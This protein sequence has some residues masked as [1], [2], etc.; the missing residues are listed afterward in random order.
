MLNINWIGIKT[1]SYKEIARFIS[2]Y[3]Q[4]IIAP[5]I[6][7]LIFIAIF[8]FSLNEHVKIIENI[9]FIK[10]IGS[11]LIMMTI[12]QN[13]YA[14]TS[15]ILT[16]SKISGFISDYIMPPISPMEL[17]FCLLTGS[18]ARSILVG[19]LLH[20]VLYFTIDLGITH[21]ALYILYILLS[22]ILLGILGIITGIFANSFDQMSAA[23]NYII[24]PLS[25]LSGT[26]YSIHQLPPI[27][28]NLSLVNPFFYLIDGF[29]YAII[30]YSDQS[31]FIG[32]SYLIS[33]IFISLLFCYIAL[34]KGWRIKN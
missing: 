25:F 18:I 2:V 1:L 32:I 22:S 17:I 30:G 4:T 14:N 6:T 31:I 23:T 16:M 19:T 12:I 15:S 10:F 27:L 5:I 28:L 24:V 29:R 21:I 20:L 7:S 9:S 34:Y 3:H 33:I 8:Y 13:S 11:G 26:F